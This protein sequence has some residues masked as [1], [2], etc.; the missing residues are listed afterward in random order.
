MKTA[1]QFRSE[2]ELCSAFIHWA[3]G[4]G[5]TPYAETAGWDI[6]L[7]RADGEQLGIQAKLHFN[8]CLLRQ[9]L[10]G[11]YEADYKM[12]GPD[13][14]AIL[15]P[16]FDR[17][18]DDVCDGIGV[19]YFWPL[20]DRRARLP[21]NLRSCIPVSSGFA[22]DLE[23]GGGPDWWAAKRVDLPAYIPDV[24]A[25]APSPVTLTEWK[26]K[27]LRVCALLELKGKLTSKQIRS[28][29]VDP[30]NWIHPT[31]GWLIPCVEAPG[32]Y[33]RGPKLRFIQ[34][35]PVVYRQILAEE[36]E[37]AGRGPAEAG[38]DR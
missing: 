7:S 14:R 2:A 22:P 38:G 6:L 26:Q 28:A 34:Q 8:A 4:Q 33:A 10:P 21:G 35:H 32:Y 29:G 19:G 23:A 30:R 1:P 3:E 20:A 11:R 5:W 15:L 12:A 18:V 13:R 16:K 25:G 37:K 36:R 27:A 31:H 24:Q 9:V 17:E